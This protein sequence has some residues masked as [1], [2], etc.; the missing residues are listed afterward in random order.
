MVRFLLKIA[1][2]LAVFMAAMS[3]SLSGEISA[4]GLRQVPP[5]ALLIFLAAF[6]LTEFVLMHRRK[7]KNG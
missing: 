7:A 6:A 3:Y 5:L 2:G 4:A 1:I